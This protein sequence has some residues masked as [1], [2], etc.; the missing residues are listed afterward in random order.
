MFLYE[1]VIL[2]FARQVQQIKIKIQIDV[3]KQ[4]YRL[5]IAYPIIYNMYCLY[6]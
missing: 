3:R 2:M 1:I 4:L 6:N 5:Y